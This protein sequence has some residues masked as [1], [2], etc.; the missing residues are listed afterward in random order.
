MIEKHNSHPD[1]RQCSICEQMEHVMGANMNIKADVVIVGSG[2]AGLY[3]A[4]NLPEDKTIRLI[5][6]S[7]LE[8]SDS[9]L[10]QGG[11]CVLKEEADYESFFTDTLKAGHF[12]NDKAAVS[13]M[14]RKSPEVIQDLVSMGVEFEQREGKFL[15]TKEGAHS[16][17]RILYHKDIT[18][19]EITQKLLAQVKKKSNIILME[20]T[21]MID[22]IC[23][24][25][26]CSGVV[27]RTKEGINLRLDADFTVLATGG[28]GGL[29]QASTNYP[30][31]TGD[32][33]ALA[34]RHHIRLKNINYIQIHPTTLYT[35][36]PGRRFLISESVRGEG[37]YLLN[38]KK[39]R[40]VD[41]LLPRDILTQKIFQ[42]MKKE[43]SKHVWL[44][45]AHM[46][47]DVVTG[48]FPNI[49][50]R[51]REEGIDI[52]K[53]CIPVT[54]AQHY[55]MGGIEAGLNSKTSMEHLYAVGETSCNGVH[56]ANRLASNSL[57]E[58]LVF[59]RE[60]AK[61]ILAQH[62]KISF[63]PVAV[64]L[65][66]YY[67]YGKLQAKNKELVLKE[68]ERAEQN[69]QRNNLQVKYG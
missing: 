20:Y 37:A 26:C 51:C 44:S 18:G 43:G 25:N 57:L 16:Q 10:A 35:E 52:T 7:S 1:L 6:K 13:R 31:L 60:A 32:S 8:M 56:G 33:L 5:T 15:Y 34:V 58:S 65:A 12:E 42:Q 49:Y 41:E 23:S 4:L 17:P 54:P 3:C 11:I 9:Y 24:D 59:A 66:Q 27:I 29:Y 69:V 19:Q 38:G 28:I 68:I 62:Q 2:A 50:M 61:D 22:L 40:F 21:E 45:V 47:S 30:H 67:D 53:D 63:S 36:K 46:G 55:F 48:R 14:I 64:D 39:E